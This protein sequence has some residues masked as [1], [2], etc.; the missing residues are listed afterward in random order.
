LLHAEREHAVGVKGCHV[1]E[2]DDGLE[3]ELTEEV[4]GGSCAPA[5]SLPPPPGRAELIPGERC[6]P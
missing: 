5:S 3:L 1:L 6:T 2:A 4:A